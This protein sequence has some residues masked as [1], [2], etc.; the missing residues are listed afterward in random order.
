MLISHNANVSYSL[1]N[2][3]IALITLLDFIS[4]VESTIEFR[5]DQNDKIEL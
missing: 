1:N 4:S 5:V 3:I 2:E